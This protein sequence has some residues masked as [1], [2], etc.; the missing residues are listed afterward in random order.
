MTGDLGS[1]SN[2]MATKKKAAKKPARKKPGCPARITKRNQELIDALCQVPAPSIKE[3]AA[4]LSMSYMVARQ[5]L[6]KPIVTEALE[7]ARAKISAE[8]QKKAG[9][10]KAYVLE[11]AKQMFERCMQREEVFEMVDGCRVSSGEW[12]FD[13]AGA[14]KALKLMGDHIEVNA[15]KALD[16]DGKP[17]DQNWVV[18]IVGTDGQTKK[19]LGPTSQ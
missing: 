7:A 3:A 15:F 17:I 6:L 13:S 4:S 1:P 5:M 2:R 16:D 9:V 8:A 10:D 11:G 19:T 12:K 18:T 14:G